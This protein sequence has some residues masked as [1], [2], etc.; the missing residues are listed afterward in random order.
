[1]AFVKDNS[2]GAMRDIHKLLLNT[3]YGRLG[4]SNDKDVIKRVTPQEYEKL[5]LI[6]NILLSFPLKDGRI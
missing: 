4:M 5:E 6:Y 3:P 1:M 2:T